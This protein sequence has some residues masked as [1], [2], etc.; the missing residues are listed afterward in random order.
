LLQALDVLLLLEGND[1]ALAEARLP[2]HRI[3]GAYQ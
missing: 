1:E 3:A 2:I